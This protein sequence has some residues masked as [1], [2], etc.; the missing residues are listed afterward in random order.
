MCAVCTVLDIIIIIIIIF[1]CFD[2]DDDV[3]VV[4]EDGACT[5]YTHASCD[6]GALDLVRGRLDYAMLDSVR[7]ENQLVLAVVSRELQEETNIR[8]L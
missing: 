4:E 7:L 2:D 6:A 5:L 3:A 8:G 1:I